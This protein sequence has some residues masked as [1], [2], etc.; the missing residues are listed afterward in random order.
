MNPKYE[1]PMD[2]F[3]S[4]SKDE[5]IAALCN[6]HECSK[7]IRAVHRDQFVLRQW[8]PHPPQR[9]VAWWSKTGALDTEKATDRSWLGIDAERAFNCE[10]VRQVYRQMKE[11]AAITGDPF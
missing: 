6:Y 2:V 10:A 7:K 9:F 5:Q 1:V 8:N 3:N 4:M 11:L